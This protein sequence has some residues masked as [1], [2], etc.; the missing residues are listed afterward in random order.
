MHTKA[1][2]RRKRIGH[3]ILPS[4]VVYLARFKA[5]HAKNVYLARV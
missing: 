4:F 1:S 5:L 2:P 3:D